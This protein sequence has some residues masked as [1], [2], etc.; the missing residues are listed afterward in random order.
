[1]ELNTKRNKI[2]LGLVVL[3]VISIILI[4][5]LSVTLTASSC[6]FIAEIPEPA[7]PKVRKPENNRALVSFSGYL[8]YN[9]DQS[10]NSSGR[11]FMPLELQSVGLI[12]LFEEQT[13]RLSLDA[14]CAKMD[15]DLVQGSSDYEVS[16]I[17]VDLVE[18]NGPAKTCTIYKTQ[19][20]I[21]GNNQFHYACYSK[22]SYDCYAYDPIKGQQSLIARLIVTGLE[23][24]VDGDKQVIGQGSFS[25]QGKYCDA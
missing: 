2:I 17:R 15:L 7:H 24:E 11:I 23:F 6:S 21:S 13:K 4:V 22:R 18:P 8:I 19:L 14:N 5:T 3:V 16:E 25:T 9:V 20:D 12:S 10:H 1:M